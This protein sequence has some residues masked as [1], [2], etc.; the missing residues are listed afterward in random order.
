M[1]KNIDIL[2]GLKIIARFLWVL[3]LL[4]FVIVLYG[5]LGHHH[6][7]WH[8]FDGWRPYHGMMMDRHGMRH[9]HDRAEDS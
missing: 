6:K 5:C 2:R 8:G 3:I 7:Y 4:W 9:E 1:W